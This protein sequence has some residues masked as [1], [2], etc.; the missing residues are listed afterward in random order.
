MGDSSM[1][2]QLL[3]RVDGDQQ[4]GGT[5]SSAGGWSTPMEHWQPGL[6]RHGVTMTF[7]SFMSPPHAISDGPR[8]PRLN[9]PLP[10]KT[11]HRAFVVPTPRLTEGAPVPKQDG[12]V[13]PHQLLGEVVVLGGNLHHRLALPL[14]DR[15][16]D[17]RASPAHL[18]SSSRLLSP[19][20]Y[21]VPPMSYA[22]VWET[23][24]SASTPPLGYEAVEDHRMPVFDWT[25]TP[26]P[27]T[28]DNITNVKAFFLSIHLLFEATL[29][30]S[31]S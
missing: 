3:G 17:L 13:L 22:A 23:R 16:E 5:P 20:R 29:P 10:V 14:C 2:R 8:P 9:P 12:G 31:C 28:A 30:N 15:V 1:R 11:R 24:S 19:S 4:D 25:P 26:T 6:V 27:S 21:Q 7:P 18:P